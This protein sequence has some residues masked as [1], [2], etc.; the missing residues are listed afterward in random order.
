[1]IH[2]LNRQLC[3]LPGG[4]PRSWLGE[5]WEEAVLGSVLSMGTA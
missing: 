4:R 3:S 5:S 1:V 2:T